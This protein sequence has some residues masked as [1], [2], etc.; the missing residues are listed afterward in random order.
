MEIL[1]L[2]SKNERQYEYY[3]NDQAPF[4]FDENIAFLKKGALWY[5]KIE[6]KM[7]DLKIERQLSLA[8][9]G[10]FYEIKI[11]T[12]YRDFKKYIMGI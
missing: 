2:I 3:L 10:C 6:D 7:Y 11:E 9:E 1:V 5:L 12:Y 8:P 4:E